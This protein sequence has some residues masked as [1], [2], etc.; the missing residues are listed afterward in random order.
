MD[1][2]W[3]LWKAEMGHS[4]AAAET[5]G[6]AE[7]GRRAAVNARV[8]TYQEGYGAGVRTDEEEEESEE[9]GSCWRTEALGGG[10]A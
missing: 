5:W 2:H 7:A 10:V 6:Q 4:K 9:A 8:R 3:P 1:T